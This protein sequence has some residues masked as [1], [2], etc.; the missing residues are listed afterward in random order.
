M[1]FVHFRYSGTSTA[2]HHS[3]VAKVGEA[4]LAGGLVPLSVV[5]QEAHTSPR[6]T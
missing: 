6:I 1:F 3:P 5:K 2:P 4:Q